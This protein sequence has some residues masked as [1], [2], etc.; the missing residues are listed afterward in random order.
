MTHI[1]NIHFTQQFMLDTRYKQLERFQPLSFYGC[2][3]LLQL[4]KRFLLS[5]VAEHGQKIFSAFSVP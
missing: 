5:T 1:F 3:D 2:F 4:E